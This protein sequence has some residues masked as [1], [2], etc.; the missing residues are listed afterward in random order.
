GGA[1]AMQALASGE[2][3][4]MMGELNSAT[5]LIDAGTVA[6]IA[7]TSP[8]RLP[9]WPDVPTLAEQGMNHLN[10][11]A[12]F[13]ILAPAGTPDSVVKKLSE[14]MEATLADPEFARKLAATGNVVLYS[15][16]QEYTTHL[17][18]SYRR[19]GAIIKENN[20]SPQQN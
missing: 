4:F 13:G 1:P 7:V 19:F 20:I 5:P 16:P 2:A 10:A 6:A 14:T 17:D 3:D 12:T 18:E 15:D 9:A 11:S 8:E